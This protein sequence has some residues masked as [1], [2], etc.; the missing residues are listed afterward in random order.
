MPGIETGLHRS[1]RA[2]G[3][4]GEADPIRPVHLEIPT[5]DVV[6]LTEAVGDDRHLGHARH[7]HDVRIVAVEYREARWRQRANQRALLPGGVVERAQAA[8]VFR[9]DRRD[10]RDLGLH[11][12]SKSLHLSHA[13]YADL[14]HGTPIAGADPQHPRG[15]S[16]PAIEPFHQ[17]RLSQHGGDEPGGGGLA[18]RS[19]DSHDTHASHDPPTVESRHQVPSR[20]GAEPQPDEDPSSPQGR[21][22]VRHEA[23]QPRH[24][25]SMLRRPPWA[26][27]TSPVLP[28]G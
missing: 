20:R 11:Q 6:A 17:H 27:V 23:A 19:G 7:A 25:S 26:D 12:R 21:L 5:T 3:F 1:S 18:E 14:Q 9:S 22:Q 16:T 13:G 28:L 24:E 15:Q 4:E 2:C 10:H 8:M